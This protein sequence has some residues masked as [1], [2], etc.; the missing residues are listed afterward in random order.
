MLR[1]SFIIG[2][3]AWLMLPVLPAHAADM[4]YC[5]GLIAKYDAAL[6][7]GELW[8]DGPKPNG[9]PGGDVFRTYEDAWQ[10]LVGRNTTDVRRVYGVLANWDTDTT[11]IPGN[12]TMRYLN[13]RVQIVRVPEQVPAN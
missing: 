9:Y 2:L 10:F 12:S 11:S 8:K 5:Y 1:R 7:H 4:I 6:D 3:V 13:R